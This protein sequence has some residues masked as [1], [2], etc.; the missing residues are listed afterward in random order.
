[1]LVPDLAGRLDQLVDSVGHLAE[2]V[3]QQ[4]G[5]MQAGA[6]QQVPMQQQAA[7]AGLAAAQPPQ[8]A[9]ARAAERSSRSSKV[10]KVPALY[11]SKV[12]TVDD[13]VRVRCTG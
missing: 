2:A 3:S 10:H 13:A 7:A 4:Q 12:K 5:S 8:A 6:A 1:M 9:T 11:S